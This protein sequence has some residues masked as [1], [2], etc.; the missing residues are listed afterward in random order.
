MLEDCPPGSDRP[1]ARRRRSPRRA[2]RGFYAFSAACPLATGDDLAQP[3]GDVLGIGKADDLRGAP[4]AS[5][6]HTAQD[7]PDAL[8]AELLSCLDES[9]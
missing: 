5:G 4:I 8:A 3:L 7:A 2:P 9:H 1:T 6:H